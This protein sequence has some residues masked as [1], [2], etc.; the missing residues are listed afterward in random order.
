MIWSLQILR[1][2]AAL[3]VVY[4]HAEDAAL[5]ATGSSGTV[6]H[7]L[8]IVGGAGVDIFFVL[9]G[10]V[11]AK[12]APGMTSA[13]FAW[14]R[15][16]RILPI[17]LVACV[18][19]IIGK[20]FGWR[21]VVSTLLLWPATD[22]MTAPLLSVAW[23][24][25][26]E[27]LFYFCAA[28]ILHDRRWL[29]A[30]GCFYGMAFALRPLSPVFQFLGNPLAI[31]FLFGVALAYA[32][33]LPRVGVWLVPLGFAALAVSGFLHIAPNGEALDYLTGQENL[34][35]VFVY[36]LPSALIVYGFMQIRARE[37]VWTYLGEMSY[38][39]YLFHPFS[40]ALLR[41]SLWL[42]GPIQSDLIYIIA[43]AASVLF[44]WRIYVLIEMPILRAIPTPK[45]LRPAPVGGVC[46]VRRQVAHP[47]HSVQQH[48]NFVDN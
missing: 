40:I 22:V 27:M 17:Y 9:S 35:R 21:D 38:S 25:S 11:I 2:V 43:M 20:S 29:Y 6:P 24:L 44:A 10:V 8:A 30:L 3:M 46:D 28:L 26:F 19:L 42:I 4:V 33:P 23:T 37:G 47:L 45:A 41:R 32:R 18:P 48:G 34:Y 36:G 5:T 7:D 39:L 14:R 12:T 13:Q 1:F 15:I 31:E 16:R